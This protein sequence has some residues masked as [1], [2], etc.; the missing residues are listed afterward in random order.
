MTRMTNRETNKKHAGMP[1]PAPGVLTAVLDAL[2]SSLGYESHPEDE[3][4]N[5][6][7]LDGLILTLL[8]QNT[9]DRNRDKAFANLKRSHPSWDMVALLQPEEIAPFI[10]VAGLANIKSDRMKQLLEI[11]HHDFG[12]HS[13]KKMESWDVK[14][15]RA[16]LTA[17]PGIG[18]KTVACVLVFELGMP[19]FPVDTHVAR[20]SRRLGWFSEKTPP[21][22][23]QSRLEEIMPPERCRGAHLNII[24][25]GRQVC[26]ARKPSCAVCVIKEHCLFYKERTEEANL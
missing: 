24:E 21:E 18:P 6:D 10:R 25:H 2:E 8:S 5:E 15:A 23:I 3:F 13:L 12:A 26:H 22:K 1:G 9:N 19:A 20:I 16:Y 17:L 7:P 11:I 4:K 14:D